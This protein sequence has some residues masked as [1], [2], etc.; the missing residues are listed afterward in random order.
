M[1]LTIAIFSLLLGTKELCAHPVA[2]GTIEIAISKTKIELCIRVSPEEVFVANLFGGQTAETVS[3]AYQQHGD[4]LLKHLRFFS[5]GR[6][7]TGKRIGFVA[8]PARAATARAAYN[9][10]YPITEFPRSISLEE[11]VLNEFN[12]GPGNRWE[13]TYLVRVHQGARTMV[14]SAL[15]TSKSP[16]FISL[17]SPPSHS[18]LATDYVRNGIMHILTGYDHLLFIAALALAVTSFWALFKV[19]AAFTLAHTVT[20]TLSILGLVRVPS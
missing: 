5:D 14:E 17:A 7:L 12:Y 3:I 1:R 10:E 18:Q 11:N 8:P 13:A 4:Y 6:D 9:F 2:Q 19:I 16:L 15:L 20:L